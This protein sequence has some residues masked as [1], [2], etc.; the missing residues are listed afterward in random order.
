MTADKAL[1]ADGS[2]KGRIVYTYY[3][4]GSLASETAYEQSEI[5]SKRTYQYAPY[6]AENQGRSVTRVYSTQSDYADIEKYTD[7]YG[8][9]TEDAVR[10]G[11]TLLRQ[12]YTTDLLGN[13][14]SVRDFNDNASGAGNTATYT[15]DYANRLIRKP[16]DGV[17]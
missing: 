11:T 17:Q 14:T 3:A 2:E 8:Y 6:Y 7:K 4:D 5:I 16:T 10:Y 9:K 15:Y 13:I 1:E 12:T